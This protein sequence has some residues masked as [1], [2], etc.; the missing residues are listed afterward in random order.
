MNFAFDEE[1]QQLRETARAF[2]E[3]HSDSER[4]RIAMESELGFDPQVWKQISA[5]LGWTAITIPEDYG[6]LG[7]SYV[8]LVALL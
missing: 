8:E 5:E 4:V 1:Q 6:G 7:L 2:L 3:E